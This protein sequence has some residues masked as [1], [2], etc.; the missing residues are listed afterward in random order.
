MVFHQRRMDSTANS[1]VSASVPTL[2][3]PMFAAMSY[4]PYGAT[5]PRSLSAKS[6]TN[7]FRG[8]PTGSYSR[9]SAAKFPTSC[10]FFVSTEITGSPAPVNSMACE[11]R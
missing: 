7:T 4:T 8:C 3:H 11:F 10:F 5:L 6:W 9:P 2:T 1:P